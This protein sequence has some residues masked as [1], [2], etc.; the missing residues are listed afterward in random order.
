MEVGFDDCYEAAESL[1]RGAGELEYLFLESSVPVFDS[2]LIAKQETLT[3]EE[4]IQLVER[5]L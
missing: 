5:R 2:V 1:T 3:M 4:G